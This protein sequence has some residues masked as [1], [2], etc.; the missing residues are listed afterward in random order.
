MIDPVR[1]TDYNRTNNELEELLLFCIAVAGKNATTTSKN[2][3]N[4]LNFG[5]CYDP[6]PFNTIRKL[7]E[8][9][10]PLSE[11]MKSMGFG[12]YTLKS[13]GFIEVAYF[14]HHR[15]NL[16]TCTPQQLEAVSG[17]G[18]KTSR[19]FILHTRKNANVACLDTHILKWMEYYTGY[20][21]PNKT[22]SKTKYLELEQAF[23]Q[24]AKVM[25]MS[26]ADL[27]LLIWNKQRG[28]DEESVDKARKA[29]KK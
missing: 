19:F 5:F 2:L 14:Q 15:L 25:K 22:P 28:S 8:Q 17:I 1:I 16:R 26:A 10:R 18:M 6:S 13:R 3:D 9:Y 29:K 4:L 11:L 20:D 23:L 27:D 21:V 12:C 24:I 7:A